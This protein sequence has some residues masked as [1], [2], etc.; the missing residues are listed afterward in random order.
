[1]EKRTDILFP[2][3][4]FSRAVLLVW[5]AALC[6]P[7]RVAC[8]KPDAALEPETWQR[9]RELLQE[10]ARAEGE[11]LYDIYIRLAQLFRDHPRELRYLDLSERCARYL[12][13]PRG[14]ATA[15]LMRLEYF[16]LGGDTRRLLTEADRVGRYLLDH[17]DERAANVEALIIKRHI[18]EGRLQTALHAARKMLER[19]GKERNRYR[20]AYA[21]LSVGTAYAAGG[22]YAE[23]VEALEKSEAAMRLHGNG[24]PAIDRIR[25]GLE[26]IDATYHTSDYPGSLRHCD[27]TLALL[28]VYMADSRTEEQRA[29]NYRSMHLYI[30]C[31]Y[32][33]N[34]VA[35]GETERAAE[36]L[37]R[38][39]ADLYEHIGLDGEFYNE[40]CA[41]YYRAAGQYD[42]ALAYAA[43]SVE[44]FRG[45]D[46]M[47]YYLSALQLK[48]EIE[49]RTGAWREAYE[50]MRFICRAKDSL[51]AGRFVM[52]LSELHTL[53][54]VDKFEA[55]KARQRMIIL[56]TGLGCLL[57]ALVVCIYAVYSFRLRSKNRSLYRQIRENMRS[58]DKAARVL[59]MTAEESLT[60]EMR[61]FRR[62]A[63]LMEEERPF[64][65]PAFGRS[66]LVR[67]LNTNEKY[68]ADAVR[69]GA[70]VTVATYIS[71]RRL[72]YSLQLLT[73]SPGLSIEQVAER[74]GHGA[75]SSYFRAFTRKFSMSPSQYRRLY[76]QKGTE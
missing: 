2:C 37:R 50:N 45:R 57:L 14:V 55:Q 38:A 47:P 62:I 64:T 41:I 3:C 1:M 75:Y 7:L 54:E 20:E 26:L 42:R 43:R 60:R 18:D 10:A 8:Q 46:L 19:A 68:L 35:L 74:S 36:Y 71:D 4:R 69:E 48:T 73:E 32:V 24:F 44:A 39:E 59:R 28:E 23:A 13:S 9:E 72:N 53:Y 33:R 51:A 65:D 21:Y 56:F 25:V 15:M 34:L 17:A 76:F 66:A 49:A 70:G 31:S 22:Q 5:L 16:A 63:R 11:A 29:V 52:Q 6:F 61:L 67:L 40:T 12:G 30:L 27:T 58:G